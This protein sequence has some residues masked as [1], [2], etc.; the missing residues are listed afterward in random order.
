MKKSKV[1]RGVI[2]NW[3]L[4]HL[5]TPQ[6]LIDEIYPDSTPVVFTGTVVKDPTGRRSPNDHTR[7]SLIVSIDE[8]KGIIETIN[9]TYKIIGKEG[10]DIFGDLGDKVL[11]IFY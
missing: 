10:G 2:K 1:F 9:S 5:S 8:D 7:S 6:G 4:H 11:N 3:Q